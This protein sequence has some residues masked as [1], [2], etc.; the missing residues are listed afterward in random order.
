MQNFIT[1]LEW[2]SDY[3]VLY[4]FYNPNKIERY[5]RYMSDKWVAFS[6]PVDEC[7][8]VEVNGT[9]KYQMTFANAEEGDPGVYF[10]S[11]HSLTDNVSYAYNTQLDAQIKKS[12]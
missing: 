3:Y 8:P 11:D 4:F 1:K 6:E 7:A 9:E 5:Y 12:K 2:I 10:Q